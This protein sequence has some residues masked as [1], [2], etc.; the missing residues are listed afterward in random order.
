MALPADG[1]TA[2]PCPYA[3]RRTTDGPPSPSDAFR[4]HMAGMT[5]WRVIARCLGVFGEGWAG[6]V[7]GAGSVVRAG[8]LGSER[9]R[10]EGP[11]RYNCLHVEA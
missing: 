5:R 11:A 2:D 1:I 8:G 3:R 6:E 9:G 4:A 10:L 7:A